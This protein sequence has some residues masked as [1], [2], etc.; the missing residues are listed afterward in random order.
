[1][2]PQQGGRGGPQ[3]RDV[4]GTAQFDGELHQV[5]VGPLLVVEGVE[6]KTL[7]Q[8]RQ[9]KNLFD[10]GIHWSAPL[11]RSRRLIGDQPRSSNSSMSS[12]VRVTNG[13]SDGV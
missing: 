9:G 3:R 1:M 13:M 8:R 2:P 12:W 6:E 11:G 5:D 4:Q 7:L 10:P